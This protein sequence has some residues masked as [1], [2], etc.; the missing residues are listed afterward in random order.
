MSFPR[1]WNYNKDEEVVYLFVCLN[2]LIASTWLILKL[3]LKDYAWDEQLI[4]NDIIM[5]L[6]R[7]NFESMYRHRCMSCFLQLLLFMII[8]LLLVIYYM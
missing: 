4:T 8:N 3:V 5:W 1:V 7:T 2:E 6:F